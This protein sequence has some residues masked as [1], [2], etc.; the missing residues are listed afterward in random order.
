V[1]ID[2]DLF[3]DSMHDIMFVEDVKR[4]RGLCN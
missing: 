2:I 3:K 4:V 1:D